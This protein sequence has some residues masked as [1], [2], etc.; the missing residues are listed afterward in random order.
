MDFFSTKYS[1]EVKELYKIIF[2]MLTDE[3]LAL[4]KKTTE[5]LKGIKTADDPS[6]STEV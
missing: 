2:Q 1:S 3:Q 6:T 4:I 5:Q